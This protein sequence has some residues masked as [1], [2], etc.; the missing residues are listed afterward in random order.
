MAII[1]LPTKVFGRDCSLMTKTAKVSPPLG[2]LRRGTSIVE[3]WHAFDE[4]KS[5]FIV[6]KV[7]ILV[8]PFRGE[9]RE[10]KKE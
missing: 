8:S 3:E 10:R 6:S 4:Y 7:K 9:E 5:V 1:A 2:L